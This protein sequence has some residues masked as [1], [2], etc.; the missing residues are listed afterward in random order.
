[1]G[2]LFTVFGRSDRSVGAR[3]LAVQIR[4]AESFETAP[5]LVPAEESLGD[6]W[7]RLE[8][9]YQAGRPPVVIDS[10]PGERLAERLAGLRQELA[11]A[12]VSPDLLARLDGTRQ[13]FTIEVVKPS[14]TDEAWDMLDALEGWLAAALE[15]MLYAP[16]DG[17]Y[18]SDL[19]LLLKLPG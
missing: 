19:R 8:V 15:G 13:I 3:E 16:H 7:Q 9:H 1:V 17:L 5:R 12:R 4:E 14:L 6:D 11:A 2:Y 10:V 18:D